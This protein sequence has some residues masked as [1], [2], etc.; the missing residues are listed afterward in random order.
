MAM[1][2]VSLKANCVK[3]AVSL[4]TPA[5]SPMKW[6]APQEVPSKQIPRMSPNR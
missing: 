2:E 5:K 1:Q 3:T 4:P 6:D